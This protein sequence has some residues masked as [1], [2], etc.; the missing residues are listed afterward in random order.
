MKVKPIANI[1][2]LDILAVVEQEE[3]KGEDAVA[4]CRSPSRE[5]SPDLQQE[6]EATGSDP[7]PPP[8]PSSS[9]AVVKKGSY[10]EHCEES[11]R[12]LKAN[13]AEFVENTTMSDIVEVLE[14][15]KVLDKLKFAI[16]DHL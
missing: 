15:E 3:K 7:P 9:S 10:R 11:F 4:E 16:L 1:F 6:N 8:P 12:G 13:V 5:S 14:E 2:L